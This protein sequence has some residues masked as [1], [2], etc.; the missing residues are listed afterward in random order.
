MERNE[1]PA[2]VQC[3]FERAVTDFPLKADLWLRY[4]K[5]LVKGDLHMALL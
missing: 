2:R 5:Y 4:G 3:L 1:D